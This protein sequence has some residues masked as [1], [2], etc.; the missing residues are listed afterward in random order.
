MK[1][2]V[3]LLLLTALFFG[4]AFGCNAAKEAEAAPTAEPTAVPTAEPIDPLSE[5]AE[6]EIFAGR[7]ARE[8]GYPNPFRTHYIET[9]VAVV[10]MED[11]IYTESVLHEAE[12]ML[13]ADMDTIA[14]ALGETP[15]RVTV[16]LVQRMDSPML[17]NG[18]IVCTVDDL[19]SG[20]YR[21][22]LCGACYQLAIPWKQIGLSAYVFD[23]IDESGLSEYYA[24]EAHA[25]TASCAAVYLLDGFADKATVQA[26]RKT[27]QS[28]TLYLLNN[29]GLTALQSVVSTAEI[30]PAW[31]A[32]LGIETPLILPEG[33]EYAGVVTARSDAVYRC[34]V[35]KD[36]FSFRLEKNCFTDTPDDLYRFLCAYFSGAEMVLDKIRKEIP[37][38]AAIAEERFSS[39]I[40]V[41]LMPESVGR[42]GTS[43]PERTNLHTGYVAPHELV[44]MLLWT[45]VNE[46]LRDELPR[47][48]QNEALA[49]HFSLEAIT[50]AFP[51]PEFDS[52]DVFINDLF[53]EEWTIDP[54]YCTALWNVYCAGKA[55]NAIAGND[56]RDEY[57]WQRAIGVCGLLFEN[58]PLE[59]P[60][61][62]VAA[63]YGF[64]PEDADGFGL[65]YEEAL[66][67]MEYLFGRFGTETVTDAYMNRVPFAEA[68][69]SDYE[70]LFGDCIAYLRNTYGP[71]LAVS[72]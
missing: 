52:F 63:M 29:G 16:Y 49:E 60:E 13:A 3:S 12:K 55:E 41:V 35:R 24:D 58:D 19:R 33:S 6:A 66:I 26:A 18:H 59:A 2:A 57:A 51:E 44:H 36:N 37:S 48:W 68:F 42:S 30:L 71:L 21:E 67:V 31:Q 1:K 23:T 34:I 53:S 69:G 54:G 28:M 27:A 8:E 14:A 46:S 40:A 10:H 22:A 17:L 45:D 64:K 61:R 72:D 25:L 11:A 70:T 38:Y 4:A 43:S 32:A 5:I 62:T 56:M 39:P 65:T 20:A 15:D 50:R 9:D 47:L 7:H